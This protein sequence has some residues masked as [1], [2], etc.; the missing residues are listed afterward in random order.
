MG[1]KL[2]QQSLRT[3]GGVSGMVPADTTGMFDQ[4][5]SRILYT[6][7]SGV[8]TDVIGDSFDLTAFLP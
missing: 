7:Q 6:I 4:V 5:K 3:I 1:T 8:V 2:Y